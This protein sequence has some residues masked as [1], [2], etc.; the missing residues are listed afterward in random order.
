MP[1]KK[2]QPGDLIEI[3]RGM[4]QHWGIYVGDGYIIHL[5]PPCEV[6]QAGACS[7]MSVLSDK[8]I[9]KKEQLW[10]VAGKDKYTV[11]NLLDKKYEPRLIH[12]ILEEA[13]SL[14]GQELP[15]CFIRGNC[16]H[17]V[18]DL[19]YGKAESRQVRK[20]VEIGVGVGVFAFLGVGVLAVASSF[21]G[22]RNKEEPQKK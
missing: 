22:S 16:E 17:F 14:L 15:Y 9:V 21:F 12:V 8:A 7:M 2:P 19:R 1:D 5:A 4:Y 6:P 18:T 10:D 13:H 20:A 11:N 3:F